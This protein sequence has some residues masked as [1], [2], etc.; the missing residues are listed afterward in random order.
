MISGSAP[1]RV[2][3]ARNAPEGKKRVA[4]SQRPADVY[5]EFRQQKVANPL[6]GHL[7]PLF[8]KSLDVVFPTVFSSKD[9]EGLDRNNSKEVQ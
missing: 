4:I 3:R 1:L 8:G 5:T 6:L 7:L 2:P 9:L